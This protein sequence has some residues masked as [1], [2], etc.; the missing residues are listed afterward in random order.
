MRNINRR[1]LMAGAAALGAATTIPE[2]A[3][4]AN[5]NFTVASASPVQFVWNKVI[6]ENFIPEATKIIEA[7]GDKVTWKELYGTMVK[8]GG[9]VQAVRD[10][11]ADLAFPTMT[12][13]VSEF[14]IQNIS[15]V[16]PFATDDMSAVSSAMHEL[17]LSDPGIAE[18]YKRFGNSYIANYVTPS[19]QLW[20]K[21]PIKGVED[22]KGLKLGCSGLTANWIKGTGAVPVEQHLPGFYNDIQ[23]GVID[24]CLTWLSVGAALKLSEVAPHITLVTFGAVCPSVI[25]VNSKIWASSPVL[26]KAFMAGGKVY[27]EQVIAQQAKSEGDA[28]KSLAAAGAKIREVSFDERVKWAGKLDEVVA[29][30]VAEVEKTGLPA[31]AATKRYIDLLQS[32]G[33]K[34]TR[35]WKI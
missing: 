11:A 13:Y 20:T 8:R 6:H 23:N 12:A 17:S 4:A 7:N 29:E 1:E 31:R 3:F 9:E 30:W 34:M 21:N 16:I 19:Y 18:T 24:G 28:M 26:Q 15:Y 33:V 27:M 35:Q 10:G 5:Y 14:P 2:L 22:L 32:K 25:S